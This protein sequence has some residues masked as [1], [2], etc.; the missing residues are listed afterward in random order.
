MSGSVDKARVVLK[1]VRKNIDNMT[2]DPM[3]VDTLVLLHISSQLCDVLTMLVE[4]A[5]P[6]E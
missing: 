6:Q 5:R 3:D 2:L 1:D 4:E